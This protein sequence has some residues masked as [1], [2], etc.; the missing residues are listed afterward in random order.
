MATIMI[1]YDI[2]IMYIV[3]TYS[4]VSSISTLTILYYINI[5][6]HG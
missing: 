2:N 4:R 3:D 1:L 5:A 6:Q